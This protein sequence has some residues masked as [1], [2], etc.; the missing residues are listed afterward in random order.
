MKKGQFRWGDE[1]ETSITVIKERLCSAPVLALPNFDKLFEVDCDV[2]IMGIRAVLS[3][4]GRPIEF[5]TKK[6]NEARQKWTTYG[7]EFY[8]VIRALKHWELYLIN[9]EF[10]LY[11]DHQALKF[12]NTQSTLNRMYARWIAFMHKF[13]FVI[14]HKSIGTAE[15]SG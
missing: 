9:Q 14:K 3:Q 7:L 10:V 15:Q 12:V 5:F 11:S 1:Q 8:A 2:S 13:S 4:E 6:R